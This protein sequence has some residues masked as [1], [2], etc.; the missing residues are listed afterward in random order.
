MHPAPYHP[1][2]FAGLL[3]A[4][5]LLDLRFSEPRLDLGRVGRGFG[6]G[7]GYAAAGW[8]VH[9]LLVEGV[10]RVWDGEGEVGRGLREREGERRGAAV[11]EGGEALVRAEGQGGE[12]EGFGKVFEK[13]EELA[14][15]EVVLGVVM[16]VDLK[17]GKR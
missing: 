12:F 4:A 14:K 10:G 2:K 17:G 16:G 13:L 5:R 3:R 11:Y 7:F 9:R 8:A 15:P 6:K 1:A